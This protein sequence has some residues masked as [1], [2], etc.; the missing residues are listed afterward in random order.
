M[1]TVRVLGIDASLN[2][3]GIAEVNIN[4]DT[5]ALTVEKV[6]VIQ[7]AKADTVAKRV[8]RKNS[9]DLR[10]ARWLQENLIK[11]CEGFALVTVEMPFGS[12]SARAMASYGICIG[13]LSSCPLP[14]IEVTPAEVKLAGHGT[15]TASKK[16]MIEW[17]TNLHPDANWR[18]M[19]RKDEQV[20]T[21]DNEHSADALASVYAAMKTEQFKSVMAIYKSMSKVA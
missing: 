7:P 4:L 1:R 3:F 15:K 19:K 6:Y 17:A 21:N 8:V 2:N 11:A 9:D 20:L 18:T 13:V 14:M 12:Q 5:L 16:E 10:R